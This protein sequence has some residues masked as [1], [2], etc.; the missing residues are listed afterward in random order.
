[1]GILLRLPGRLWWLLQ[2][3]LPQF[4][5]SRLLGSLSRERWQRFKTIVIRWWIIRYRVKMDEAVHSSPDDYANFVSF[6]TRPI[7]PELRPFPENRKVLASPVDGTL[8]GHGT[9]QEGWLEQVK[10]QNYRLAVLLGSE[11]DAKRFVGCDYANFYLSPR[12]YHRVHMP[13]DGKLHTTRRLAGRLYSVGM[14]S[15]HGVPGLYVGNRRCS[16]IFRTEHGDMALV[17]VGAFL[18]GKIC[19]AWEREPRPGISDWKGRLRVDRGNEV[20][21]FELGSAAILIAPPGYRWNTHL[22]NRMPVQV[23]MPLAMH[24]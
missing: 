24:R 12:D 18:V 1:M 19:L 16:C 7:K 9:V 14:L 20:G 4:W 21:R 2:A 8:R 5:I 3:L 17:M 6:F 10:G 13:L 23:G 22:R 15:R 11:Q